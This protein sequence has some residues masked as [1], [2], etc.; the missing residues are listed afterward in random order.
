VVTCGCGKWCVDI[1]PQVEPPLQP[2]LNRFGHGDV[3]V[4]NDTLPGPD[5]DNHA[6]PPPKLSVLH[7]GPVNAG[8]GRNSSTVESGDQSP[9]N[10]HTG[11]RRS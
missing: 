11:P 10:P 8:R 4:S 5:V 1:I 2:P 6:P 9:C 3:E 7:L